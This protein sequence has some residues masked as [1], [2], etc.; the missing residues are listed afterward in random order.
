MTLP[1]SG[2]TPLPESPDQQTPGRGR[3]R[4]APSAVC[5]GIALVAAAIWMPAMETLAQMLRP[6]ELNSVP[7]Y[8]R[9]DV[10]PFQQAAQTRMTIIVIASFLVI[11]A[12]AMI[13]IFLGRWARRRLGNQGA[14]KRLDKW[15]GVCLIV[16]LACLGFIL[17]LTLSANSMVQLTRM[18]FPAPIIQPLN[19]VLE[20]SPQITQMLVAVMAMGAIGSLI[21]AGIAVGNPHYQTARRWE[22]WRVRISLVVSPLILLLWLA[23]TAF[24]ARFFVALYLHIVW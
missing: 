10:R 24:L 14:M 11:I 7:H 20:W 12:L 6:P 16:S 17:L 5:G 3:W 9:G 8:Y 19:V 15:A 4:I 21:L 18:Q 1:P 22:R 23:F 2:P 13:A